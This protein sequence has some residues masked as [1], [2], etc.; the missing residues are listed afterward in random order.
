MRQLSFILPRDENVEET[1]ELRCCLVGPTDATDLSFQFYGG[2]NERDVG[3][4]GARIGQH[5]RYP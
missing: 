4:I 3:G 5:A 2:G 1:L